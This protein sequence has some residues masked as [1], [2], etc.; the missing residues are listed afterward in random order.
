MLK[1]RFPIV[2][3]GCRYT[4]SHQIGVISAACVL[5]NIIISKEGL[6]LHGEKLFPSISEAHEASSNR[7]HQRYEANDPKRKQESIRASEEAREAG[8][9]GVSTWGKTVAQIRNE[10]GEVRDKMAK[11]MW[12]QYCRHGKNMI[13]S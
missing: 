1:E 9:G 4:I 6:D 13:P 11:R 5:H 2:K 3:Q 12:R 8:R 10:A 7:A